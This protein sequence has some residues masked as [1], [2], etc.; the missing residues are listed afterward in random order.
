MQSRIVLFLLPWQVTVN[1]VLESLGAPE[2]TSTL[3]YDPD[4]FVT[5]QVSARAAGTIARAANRSGHTTSVCALNWTR[6]EQ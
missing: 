1:V 6:V 4:A 2:S 3:P 5:V